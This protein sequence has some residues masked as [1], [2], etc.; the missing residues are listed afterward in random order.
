MSIA[1]VDALQG[2]VEG[3]L[4]ELKVLASLD[5]GGGVGMA[6]Q[7]TKD[8]S[9]GV[10]FEVAK[11]Y[12]SKRACGTPSGARGGVAVLRLGLAI[13]GD[14]GLCCCPQAAAKGDKR[15]WDVVS[16]RGSARILTPAGG[17]KF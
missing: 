1:S 6:L 16:V 17:S 11:V 13:E 7:G 2:R 3:A 12:L 9:A 8:A 15:R 14:G 4:F 10:V 5:V